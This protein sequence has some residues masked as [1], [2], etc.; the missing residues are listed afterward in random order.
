[1]NHPLRVDQHMDL[2]VIQVEEVVRFDHLETLIH[3]RRGVDRDLGSHRPHRVL[4]RLLD[5]RL[6]ELGPRPSAERPPRTRQHDALQVLATLT[7]K[8]QGKGRVLGVDREQP[9]GLTLDQVHHELAAD[10]EA[11]LVGERE[12]LPALERGER[13]PK[14]GRADQTV[15]H[16]VGLGFAGDGL[17]GIGTDDQLHAGERAQLLLH[18][19]GRVLVGDG[20]QR[21]QEF[22]DLPHEQILVG[23]ARGQADDLEPIGIAPDHVEGLRADGAGRAEDGERPHPVKRTPSPSGTRPAPVT[24]R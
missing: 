12:R 1:M 10:N 24:R 22:P 16:D 13:G 6:G 11:L 4:E 18:V 19:V 15:H 7:P 17:G 8:R 23:T 14:T 9:L 20:H 5:R 2:R 3:E 21:R